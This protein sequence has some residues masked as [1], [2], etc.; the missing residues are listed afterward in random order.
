VFFLQCQ[1][2]SSTPIQNY[3]QNYSYEYICFNL[4]V[5]GLSEHG[6]KLTVT[7]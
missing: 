3:R 4:C 7:D 6:D 5:F 2:Q 1:R